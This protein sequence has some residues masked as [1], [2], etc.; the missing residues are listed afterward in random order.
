[1][2]RIQKK[3]E[4]YLLQFAG[5]AFYRIE[6]RVKFRT[7]LDAGLF[8]LVLKQRERFLNDFVELNFAELRGGGA[9]EIQQRIH[10]LAGAESLARD[11]FENAGFL[12]VPGNLLAEHL[13]VSRNNGQRR[14][15][16][17]RDAG[18]QKPD[19]G[20]LVGLNQAAFKLGT[21]GDVVEDNQAA[22]LFVVA[23]NQRSDRDIDARFPGPRIEKKF[24]EVV[25]AHL[26]ADS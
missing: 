4:K 16:F 7:N 3:I 20:E 26:S 10:D 25:N 15:D 1:I 17:V 8:H 14:V 5:I 19:A 13:C 12:F 11:L 23:G 24:V 2:A 9:R 21:V 6:T 18:G 22:D